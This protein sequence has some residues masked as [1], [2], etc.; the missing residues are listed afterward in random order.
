MRSLSF[1][2]DESGDFGKTDNKNPY[3]LLTLVL[4]DQSKPLSLS[5]LEWLD[6]RLKGLFSEDSNT[7]VH[8][9]PII[10]KEKEFYNLELEDRR[11][12]INS[13][14]HFAISS[15]INYVSFIVDKRETNQSPIW[16]HN[17]LI[18]ML[19]QFIN[20]NYNLLTSYNEVKLYYDLGQKEITNILNSVFYSRLPNYTLGNTDIHSYR[21]FQV[22]DLLCTF[23][24]I[25]LKK[26]LGGFTK[27][28]TIFF[29]SPRKFNKDYYKSIKKKEIHF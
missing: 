10:R 14:F 24:L 9:G 27:S 3:Y 15:D 26:G 19:N 25:N 11:H 17:Q 2:V 1:F 20:K 8:A 29:E 28:E 23:E 7:Y 22:A 16:L 4:H 13:L 21:L 12:I 5:K 6:N 18:K